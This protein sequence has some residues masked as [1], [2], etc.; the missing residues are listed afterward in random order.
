MILDDQVFFIFYL[1]L[2]LSFS[3]GGGKI[4]KIRIILQGIF[5][6]VYRVTEFYRARKKKKK[7]SLRRKAAAGNPFRSLHPKRGYLGSHRAA[8][9]PRV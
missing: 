4:E 8:R 2:R 6:V 7:I 1:S 5:V 9:A 3:R